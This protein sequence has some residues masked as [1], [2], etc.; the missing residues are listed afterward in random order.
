MSG[1]VF[2]LK[3]NLIDH[4]LIVSEPYVLGQKCGI[5][6]VHDVVI[7]VREECPFWF[8]IR[9]VSQGFLKTEMGRVRLDADA[10]EDK[11]IEVA[12]AVH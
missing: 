8:E 4:Q 10:V 7:E 6:L 5:S 3:L 2:D 1:P 11:N 9:N 12:K